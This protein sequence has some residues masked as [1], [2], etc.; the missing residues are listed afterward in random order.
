MK[1]LAPAKVNLYLEVLSKREDNYHNIQTIFQSISLY[2]TLIFSKRDDEEI[3]IDCN[4]DIPFKENLI[5]RACQIL[6]EYSGYSRGIDIV[7]RKR[8]PLSSGLGGGS[9]D[10]ATTLLGLNRIWNLKLRREEL[11]RLGEKLGADVPYF[12]LKGTVFAE[13]IGSKL[14]LLNPLSK[15]WLVLIC[16][17][18][19]ISTKWVYEN[20]KIKLTKKRLNIKIY[21]KSYKQNFISLLKNSLEEVVIRRHPFLEEIKRK[22]LEQGAVGSLM[23]GSGPTIF[24]I[25]PDKEIGLKICRYFKEREERVYLAHTI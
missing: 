15:T 10:A 25:V 8:I 4:L 2:D 7:L 6:R 11:F 16:P 24:G 12:I 1:L 19:E 20:T 3:N 23:S 5:Y 13:G 21:L 9:S 14:T 18:L 17:K 22:L